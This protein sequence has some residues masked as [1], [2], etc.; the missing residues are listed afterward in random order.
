VDLK[1]LACG[2]VFE[3]IGIMLILYI[4]NGESSTIN[5]L[6]WIGVILMIGGPFLF[7]EV[8]TIRDTGH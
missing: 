5:S 6:K 1:K 3:F 7:W 2:F 4:G 8:L